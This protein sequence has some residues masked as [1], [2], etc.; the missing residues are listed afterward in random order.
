MFANKAYFEYYPNNSLFGNHIIMTKKATLGSLIE[1]FN[2]HLKAAAAPTI[3]TAADAAGRSETSVPVGKSDPEVT[4]ALPNG[5][6]LPGDP[7]DTIAIRGVTAETPVANQPS[8]IPVQELTR[9]EVSPGTK[10]SKEAAAGSMDELVARLTSNLKLAAE[11]KAVPPPT[12]AVLE[13]APEEPAK[14][15]DVQ[16]EK[17]V[18]VPSTGDN[19]LAA[20]EAAPEVAP[21]AAAEAAPEVKVAAEAAPEVVEAVT[22]DMDDLAQKTASFLRYSELG[23]EMASSIFAADAPV[24]KTAA[25]QLA[26]LIDEQELA[27]LIDARTGELK[28]AGLN[29]EQIEAQLELDGQAFAQ[30]KQAEFAI[31]EAT[32]NKIASYIHD[33]IVDA[34]NDGSVSVKQASELLC[35]LGFSEPAA[36]A[37]TELRQAVERKIA[38][39]VSE[40]KSEEEIAEI[41]KKD[42]E[43][44]AA[45]MEGAAPAGPEAGLP[46]EAAPAPEGAPAA[47]GAPDE[48]QLAEVLTQAI[49]ELQQAVEAGQITEDQAIQMLEESGLNVQALLEA[50][51]GAGAAPEQAA[52]EG[53][54]PAAPEVAAPAAPEG[55]ES[56]AHEASESPAKEKSEEAGEDKGEKEEK[57][58]PKEESKDEEKAEKKEAAG[59]ELPPEAAAAGGAPAG[60]ENLPPEIQA[61]LQQIDQ[62]LQSGQISEDQAMQAVE[63][64]LSGGAPAADMSADAGVPAGAAPAGAAP[65]A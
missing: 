5:G 8:N 29:D 46:P 19:K 51:G 44:D 25:P 37:A 15:P 14:A 65:I 43:F 63:A 60:L 42:A 28:T 6:Q 30:A 16:E 38:S 31:V 21:E 62:A 24:T 12:V 55:G 41:L 17:K 18:E 58:E 54:P 33:S 4:A 48:A 59:E 64:L 57:S 7:A 36:D 45:A 1:G 27:A 61:L 10:L 39:L 13:K 26:S 35:R 9:S 52:P 2:A 56:A 40:G 34:A 53:L 20:A 32:R 11:H 3:K 23:Y 50:A 47:G 22:I 49:A